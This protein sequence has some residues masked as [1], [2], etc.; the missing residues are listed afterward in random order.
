LTLASLERAAKALGCRVVYALIPDDSL[1]AQVDRQ[2]QLVA[3]ER[4]KRSEHSMLLEDQ[5][6]P[7]N[8]EEVQVAELAKEIKDKLGPDLWGTP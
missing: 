5:T 6:V 3:R 4:L 2:A 8:L 1:E 7:S